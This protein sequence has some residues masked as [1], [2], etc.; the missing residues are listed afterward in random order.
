MKKVNHFLYKIP[1]PF[2]RMKS[3][4]KYSIAQNDYNWHSSAF[5]SRQKKRE[6]NVMIDIQGDS[7]RVYII[8][9]SFTYNKKQ[10]A[11]DLPVYYKANA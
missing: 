11:A 4:R 6:N 3:F 8:N 7:K 5:I 2:H 10:N 1:F 9:V